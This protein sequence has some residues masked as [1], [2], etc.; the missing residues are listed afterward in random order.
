MQEICRIMTVTK[1]S[2]GKKWLHLR[3]SQVTFANHEKKLLSV[4][5]NSIQQSTFFQFE[6]V[7]ISIIASIEGAKSIKQMFGQNL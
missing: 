2:E 4:L 6:T 1:L 7:G 5:A 3:N